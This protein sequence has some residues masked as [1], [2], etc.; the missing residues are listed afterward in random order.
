MKKLVTSLLIAASLSV[1]TAYASDKISFVVPSSPTGNMGKIANI[2][3]PQLNE[4][5]WNIDLVVAGNCANGNHIVNSA[6]TPTLSVWI[7]RD[8]V[9]TDG[10]CV[11]E[12]PTE[13]ELVSIWYSSPDFICRVPGAPDIF[14]ATGTVRLSTQPFPYQ[15][16]VVL[17]AINEKSPADVRNI[18][19]KNSG[20]QTQGVVSG[21]VEYI[22]GTAGKRLENNGQ[23]ICDYNTSTKVVDGTHPVGDKLGFSV[24][25]EMLLYMFGTNFDDAVMTKLRADTATV[26]ASSEMQEFFAASNL[27]SSA[28]DLSVAEQLA[29]IVNTVKILK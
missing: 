4:L 22:I 11:R 1:G 16:N 10:P 18:V 29:F 20:A 2:L 26:L 25:S 3:V 15:S 5:G 23:V 13:S 8:H 6:S 9:I 21:E 7:N 27:D 17:S 19:Y 28:A 14:E 12:M 24:E